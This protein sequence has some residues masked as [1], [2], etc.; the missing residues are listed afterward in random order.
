MTN[1][2]VHLALCHT[3]RIVLSNQ[4]RIF[5]LAWQELYS[6]GRRSKNWMGIMT[7]HL[8]TNVKQSFCTAVDCRAKLVA[9]KYLIGAQ[10]LCDEMAVNSLSQAMQQRSRMFTEND[11]HWDSVNQ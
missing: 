3:C 8:R 9:Q 6:N 2:H 11:D 4:C 1:M 10:K 5:A 7:S